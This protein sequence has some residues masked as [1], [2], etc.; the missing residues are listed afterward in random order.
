MFDSDQIQG[1]VFDDIV[2]IRKRFWIDD[3][4]WLLGMSM[5]LMY[6]FKILNSIIAEEFSDGKKCLE[7]GK[8]IYHEN[9]NITP[10]LAEE[11]WAH[12]EARKREIEEVSDFLDLM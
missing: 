2:K 8:R 12:Q 4:Q 11:R 10:K 7:C 9:W 5:L 3:K 6:S 1:E